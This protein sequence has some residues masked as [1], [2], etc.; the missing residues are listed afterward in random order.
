MVGLVGLVGD[1]E[2]IDADTRAI[3]VG[4]IR[5]MCAIACACACVCV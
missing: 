3:C 4:V 5:I 2:V 1:T